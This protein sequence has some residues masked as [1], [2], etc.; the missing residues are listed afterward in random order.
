MTVLLVIFLIF[1]LLSVIYVALVMPRAVDQPDMSGMTV[2][3]AHRG[4]HTPDVPENSLAAFA[5]AV[6]EGY[7]IEL[8][9]QL[10]AD[11]KVVVFHDYTLSRMC[12]TE[13]QIART[14]YEQL[15]ELR[16]GGSEERIP[17]LREVLELVDGKV[18]L[19]VELKGESM[20][21]EL[22]SYVVEL[23]DAYGGV[24]MVES[25]NPVLLSWFKRYRPHVVRGQLVTNLIADKKAGNV[26]LNAALS[27]M[28]LNVLSRPDF[29]APNV[30]YPRGLSLWVCVSLFG[31]KAFFWTVRSEEE[32]QKHRLRGQYSIFEHITP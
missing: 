26:F 13:G 23:L 21:N 18:P 27:A 16:L 24:Y 20:N 19:L 15:R 7:G 9:V 32:Y 2:D 8:D 17:L 1:I 22:C 4:L 10:T 5:R 3:Y 30:K 25:F 11:K 6:E 12:G 28:L 14:T 29:I 31:S